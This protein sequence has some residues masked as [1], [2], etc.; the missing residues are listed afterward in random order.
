MC[1]LSFHIKLIC[2][3]EFKVR[4]LQVVHNCA[5]LPPI[6]SLP[7]ILLVY[8]DIINNCRYIEYYFWNFIF[9][10]AFFLFFITS[11]F[12]STEHFVRSSSLFTIIMFLAIS[13]HC[14]CNYS[15][16]YIT[17]MWLIKFYCYELVI[18]SGEM[19]KPYLYSVHFII[20]TFKQQSVDY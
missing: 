8:W 13:W 12:W 17:H 7:V 3:T 10:L 18:I 5:F 4:F 19:W 6:L 15:Q 9:H 1:F 16:C 14:F 11:Y 2:V 20:P